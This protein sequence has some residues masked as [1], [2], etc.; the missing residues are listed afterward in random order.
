MTQRILA[1]IEREMRK[2][3][4]SPALIFLALVLPL[5]QL[6]ILGN[7]FGG[8]IQGARIAVVDSDRGPEARRVREALQAVENNAHTF[9]TVSYLSEQEAVSGVRAG[10]IQGVVIIPPTFSRRVYSENR[11]A[12]GLV[13]DNTDQFVSS[14]ITQ[15]LS[16]LVTALN[17]PPVESRLPKQIALRMVELYPYVPYMQYMLPGA[18]ALAMFVSVMIGGGMSYIDDK[19]RGVHEGYLVTPIT[20]FELVLAM[21]IAGTLKAAAGGLSLMVLGSLLA[22]V[23][24]TFQPLHFLSLFVLIVSTSFAFMTMMSTIVARMDNPLIPRAVFGVLNTLLYFPSGAVYPVESLPRW[25]R[26]ITYVDPFTYA[27]HGLRSILL[28][29]AGLGA[30]LG[31]IACL[32]GFGL[33]MLAANTLLFKRTL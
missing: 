3:L 7:S 9:Q 15:S 14:A 30:C 10:R 31:D 5:G 27:V 22:G 2:F 19:S 18:I 17:Q 21:N 12:L 23:G 20:K 26:V 4:R 1:I 6:V 8:K 11:P 13:L 16:G 25:L 28:R 29:G 32:T 24:T 33:L